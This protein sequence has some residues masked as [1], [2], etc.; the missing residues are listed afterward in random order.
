MAGRRWL[1][2]GNEGEAVGGTEFEEGGGREVGEGLGCQIWKGLSIYRQG[3]LGF[4]F[5]VVLG[6]F[7]SLRS[8]SDGPE[9]RGF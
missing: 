5:R 8:R 6:A 1:A 3:W 7:R 9:R 4:G 2:P